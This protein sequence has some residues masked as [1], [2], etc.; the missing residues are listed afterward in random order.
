MKDLI[1]FIKKQHDRASKDPAPCAGIIYVHKR[2]ETTEIADTIRNQCGISAVAYH[3]GLKLADRN[4]AQDAWMSG[5]AS[6]AV[7]T[8]AFGMVRKHFDP[9]FVMKGNGNAANSSLTP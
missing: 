4:A 3:A 7:A 5:K 9:G 8:V 2:T 6:V 1:K